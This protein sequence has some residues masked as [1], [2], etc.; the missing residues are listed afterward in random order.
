MKLVDLKQFLDKSAVLAMTD[1][2]TAKARVVFVDDEYDDIIVDIL[3]TSRPDRY[4]DPS[5]S[6]TF[7]VADIVSAVLLP[8]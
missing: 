3:E 5:A 4:R 1:G 2:E 7:A 6:Y 8:E